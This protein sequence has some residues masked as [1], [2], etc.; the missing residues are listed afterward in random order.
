[1]MYWREVDVATQS[2]PLPLAE[3]ECP[4]HLPE[5]YRG[6]KY[7]ISCH[8]T[9]PNSRPA[10]RCQP[11]NSLSTSI[12]PLTLYPTPRRTAHCSSLAAA[13]QATLLPASLK[14]LMRLTSMKSPM[15]RPASLAPQNGYLACCWSALSAALVLSS[16]AKQGGTSVPLLS[17]FLIVL[18]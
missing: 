2:R 9:L 17:L 5:I 11:V 18:L 8:S 4:P 7:H 16:L 1:M 14:R 3:W 12:P 15:W 10:T 13:R 6:L